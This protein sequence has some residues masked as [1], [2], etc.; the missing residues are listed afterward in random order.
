[1]LKDTELYLE[2]KA[3]LHLSKMMCVSN[4][5]IKVSLILMSS[6]QLFKA[7]FEKQHEWQHHCS[8]WPE[9]PVPSL[10]PRVEFCKKV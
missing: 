8:D 9:L 4:Y 6:K 3:H 1:M 2:F 7:R 10:I 5:G